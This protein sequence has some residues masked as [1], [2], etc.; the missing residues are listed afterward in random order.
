MT[1]ESLAYWQDPA[2]ETFDQVRVP[3][4]EVEIV[5]AAVRR[6]SQKRFSLLAAKV[7]RALGHEYNTTAMVTAPQT[8]GAHLRVIED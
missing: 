8:K 2:N 1:K 5:I 3:A 6:Q 7:A 4:E